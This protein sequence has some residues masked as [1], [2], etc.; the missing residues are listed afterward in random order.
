MRQ[1]LFCL[2]LLGTL[3]FSYG[4][5]FAQETDTTDTGIFEGAAASAKML[6]AKH[7]YNE[8]N[9]RG[10]LTLY[11]EI[12]K[13]EPKNAAAHYWTARCHYALKKYSLAK[14][15]LDKAVE[16]EPD[17]QEDVLFFYGEIH[18]RLAD[19]ET[20]IDYFGQYIAKKGKVEWSKELAVTAN[21]VF[22]YLH[23]CDNKLW[24]NFDNYLARKY[25]EE[26]VY[27]RELMSHPVNVTIENMGREINTRFDE[28]A[29]SI[30]AD[31]KKIFF[32]ARRSDT[33][34][35]EIDEKGDYKFFEDVYSSTW[36]ETKEMWDMSSGV[37][38]FVNTIDYD[39][40][41]SVNPQGNK[42]FVYKN[43]PGN[44]GDIFV[45]TYDVHQD[46]WR[47]PEKM[48]RPINTS[49]FE[50]SCSMTADGEM[51]YFVSERQGGKGQGD[52]YVA[53]SKGNGQ[54]SSPKNLGDVINTELDEK[55]VFIHPNGKTLY[56]ASDGHQTMGSYD[57]FKSE[58]VNGQ[59]SIPINLGYPINTVNEESTFSLTR[60]NQMML[61]SAEYDDSNG[62]RDIYK[63]DV[64]DY[65][66]ISQGYDKSGY[67]TVI[68]QVRSNSGEV[69]KGV[70][71]K[72]L[73]LGSEKPL[74]EEK[75]D[76]AGQV[77][78]NLPGNAT[79]KFVAEYKKELV[80]VTET[81]ELN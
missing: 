20:A 18:H 17:V 7:E 66:L 19:L 77:R 5:A 3:S 51:L 45:S 41:L 22:T 58:F 6:A 68:C 62:E 55:F 31:G 40:V 11:R 49:Y 50:G 78:V 46:E 59:W 35:G 54:W 57:I 71:V 60:D 25:M 39:A 33:E 75:S 2:L 21:S 80:E 4:S 53:E 13:V 42:M 26:C 14:E 73:P 38:G 1:I 28:Y 12:L 79:Y 37:D 32:T 16:L 52:I 23:Q 76:K 24:N 48:P 47:A 36:N 56:F 15:Y 67:G 64:S 10:A 29:P 63:I 44:A 70:D 8:N 72:I 61:I 27:A 65:S 9:M 74:I 43:S 30:T 69:L 34:G 81:L